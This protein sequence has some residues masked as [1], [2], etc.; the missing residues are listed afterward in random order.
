MR[1]IEIAFFFIEFLSFKKLTCIFFN[2]APDSGW[3]ELQSRYSRNGNN[4]E[5][6]ER[7]RKTDR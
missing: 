6:M 3:M 2:R 4:E 5:E 7:D 1:M